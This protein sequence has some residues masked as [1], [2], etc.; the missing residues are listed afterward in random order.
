M[1]KKLQLPGVI[2]TGKLGY[3]TVFKNN[4]SRSQQETNQDMK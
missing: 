2:L 4:G 3:I 1:I